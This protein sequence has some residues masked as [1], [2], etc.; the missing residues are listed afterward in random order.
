[1]TDFQAEKAVL[2]A[3][4]ADLGAAGPEGVA[5]V[6]ARHAAPGW[7]WRGMH[8]FHERQGAEAVAEV[9]WA[10]LLRAVTQLQRRGYRR[11]GLVLLSRADAR[12]DH[13]WLGGYLAATAE[14]PADEFPPPLLLPRWDPALL[15]RWL[16]RHRPDAIVTR[17][18]EL[19]S[20]LA[21]MGVAV[22]REIGVTVRLRRPH[23][24]SRTAGG[25]VVRQL[26]RRNR[27]VI[28]RL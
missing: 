24:T 20:T 6:L 21:E 16:Q 23:R 14:S 2:R 15:R 4:F 5:E 8:P 18:V 27:R 3:L 22:P 26:H 7:L 25:G 12:V 1:M 17:H 13:S 9:F 28:A 10:P 11:I 19:R